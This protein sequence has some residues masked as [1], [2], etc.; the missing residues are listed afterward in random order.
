MNEIKKFEFGTFSIV[1]VADK[2]NPSLLNPDFLQTRG[3]VPQGYEL[4][5]PPLTTPPVAIVRYKQGISITVEIEKLQILE[6]ITGKLGEGE[7]IPDIAS[8]YIS[9]LPHVRYT[10]VGINWMGSLQDDNPGMWIRDR[11]LAKGSWSNEPYKLFSTRIQLSYHVDDAKCNL[12]L[13]GGEVVKKGEKPVPVVIV[14]A[15][16]HHNINEYPADEAVV[17]IINCWKEHLDH[18]LV[19]I[20]DVLGA[21]T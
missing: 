2:H 11:Y 16:Y 6:D 5:E 10:G 9:T 4:A 19:L 21:K 18:F 13:E 17:K 7:V 15:N 12:S 8:K 1:V 3:I 14:N 20:K